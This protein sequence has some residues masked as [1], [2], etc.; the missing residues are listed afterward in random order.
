M[1]A[2]KT[3][4]FI[5]YFSGKLFFQTPCI[6]LTLGLEISTL[7][8][9]WTFFVISNQM[10]DYV[11]AAR[12]TTYSFLPNCFKVFKKDSKRTRI[13]LTW[14]DCPASYVPPCCQQGRVFAASSE[15]Q[16]SEPAWSW[17]TPPATLA[18]NRKNG[19]SL[20]KTSVVGKY[21]C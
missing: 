3:A 21:L 16:N 20:E 5:Q 17:T 9:N 2:L 12:V 11:S 4:D 13:Q 19:D 1:S 8:I 18:E 10:E 15:Q 14:A 6:Y 7:D